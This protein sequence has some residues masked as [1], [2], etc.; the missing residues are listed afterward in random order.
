MPKGNEVNLK[1]IEIAADAL[2]D[3]YI[4]DLIA[5]DKKRTKAKLSKSAKRYL[6]RVKSAPMRSA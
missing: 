2:V 3:S 5:L 1:A 4:A 6:K